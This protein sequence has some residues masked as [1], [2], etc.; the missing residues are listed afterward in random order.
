VTEW[1][2][3][4]VLPAVSLTEPIEGGLAALVPSRDP[5]VKALA[6]AHPIFRSFL[7]RFTDT[8][9]RKIEPSVLIVP[10]DVPE[11]A[12]RADALS[13][14]RDAI[15]LSVIPYNRALELRYPQGHRVLW[16]DYFSIYPWMI[17]RN[18]DYVIGHTPAILGT[19]DASKFKGQSSPE[20]FRM[21]VESHAI[22]QP[23]LAQLLQS[24]RKR[25]ATKDPMIQERALFRSLNMA[26]RAAE[27]P[28]GAVI[29]YYDVGRSIALWVPA[30]EILAHPGINGDVNLSRV[31][32]ML[33]R[34]AWNLDGS[35]IVSFR[36]YNGRNRSRILK[37]NG[38]WLYGE[39][40]HARNDFLH[41]N[42]V[43]LNRL[44]IQ[45]SCRNLSD[46]AAP[47]YR[48]ALTSFLPLACPAA[49]NSANDTEELATFIADQIDFIDTQRTI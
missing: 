45:G 3:V 19:D 5:R 11:T 37:C 22:D 17:D 8:F 38:S 7:S 14:F 31:Y 49:M 10:H 46:L 33:D 25:Y 6:K 21:T 35:K 18:Y 34:A 12:Y 30:F 41:G 20:L 42:P 4:V 15:A 24:W 36:A 32:G 27:M 1:K 44:K 9:K 23:L 29:T 43:E 13:S 26:F 2:P 48:M 16:G 39:L 47:L 28:A 40:Y